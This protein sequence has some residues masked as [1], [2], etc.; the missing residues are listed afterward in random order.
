MSRILL[1]LFYLK[2]IILNNI[3]DNVNINN[4]KEKRVT[5]EMCLFF[6]QFN[7]TFFYLKINFLLIKTKKSEYLFCILFPCYFFFFTLNLRIKK[8]PKKNQHFL[9]K[10]TK[11]T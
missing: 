1:L 4:N 7:L 2:N 9:Y 10:Y 8:P 6:I 11:S 3:Y 5:F